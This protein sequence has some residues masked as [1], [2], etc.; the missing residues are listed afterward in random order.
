[1]NTRPYALAR[2]TLAPAEKLR[3]INWG[4]VLLIGIIACAG[5]AMLYS[6]ADGHLWPWAAPQM[7][8]FGIGLVIMVAVAVSDIRFWLSA[9]LR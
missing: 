1:M 9:A 2:R 5:F 6:D 3:E 4:L 8:R 7:I